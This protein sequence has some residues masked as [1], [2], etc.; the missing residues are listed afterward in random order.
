MNTRTVQELHSFVRSG[1]SSG[2]FKTKPGD[3]DIFE[4]FPDG[5]KKLRFATV[6]HQKG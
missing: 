1:S 2:K 5:R 6:P 4:I 3:G